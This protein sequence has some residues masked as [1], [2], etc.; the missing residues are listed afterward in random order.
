M[1][2]K[3]KAANKSDFDID[4]YR[5]DHQLLPEKSKLKAILTAVNCKERTISLSTELFYPKAT[6]YWLISALWRSLRY[7]SVSRNPHPPPLTLRF[8]S[9][10]GSIPARENMKKQF[11]YT[12]S[13]MFCRRGKGW[14]LIV[15]SIPWLYQSMEKYDQSN[16]GGRINC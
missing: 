13:P 5:N 6:R 8:T 2:R 12:R 1:L 7:W 15:T 10:F 3:R 16:W 11:L 4:S 9:L 14:N